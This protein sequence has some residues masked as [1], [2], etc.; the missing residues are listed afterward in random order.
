MSG[1][2]ETAH[3]LKSVERALE[4]A[5]ADEYSDI[6]FNRTITVITSGGNQSSLRPDV[7]DLYRPSLSDNGEFN[8]WE[9]FSPGQRAPKREL[10]LR[11]V[12]PR[13]RGFDGRAYKLLLKL[14]RAL[15]LS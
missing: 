11:P 4:W 15:G 3:A 12:A 9:V 7:A 10:E 13:M 5:E 14:L 1:G 2:V 6:Y 8:V